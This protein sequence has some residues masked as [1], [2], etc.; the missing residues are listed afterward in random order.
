M[1][2]H[3]SIALWLGDQ[4]YFFIADWVQLAVIV[5]VRGGDVQSWRNIGLCIQFI[6]GMDSQG[7]RLICVFRGTMCAIRLGHD[8]ML[9][10][11]GR[12]ALCSIAGLVNCTWTT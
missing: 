1:L 5:S 3:G 10:A 7:A 6:V 2:G 12:S 11:C 4:A 8:C 9:L